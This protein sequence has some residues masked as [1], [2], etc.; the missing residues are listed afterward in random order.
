M[1]DS[2]W[3]QKEGPIAPE[4]G[5]DNYT[6]VVSKA[7]FAIDPQYM[8]GTYILLSL[9]G[10]SPD[11]SQEYADRDVRIP[12]GKITELKVDSADVD[13][14]TKIDGGNI[15]QFPSRGLYSEMIRRALGQWGIADVLKGSG[16]WF[17][18][19]SI[20]EGLRFRF[21]KETFEYKGKNPFTSERVFP[22]DYLGTGEKV[23]ISSNGDSKEGLHAQ[24]TA[25][26]DQA[27]SHEMF[28]A[29]AVALPAV[30]NDPE[31]LA[32]VTD[33]TE[34]EKRWGAQREEVTA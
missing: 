29:F 27:A 34:A 20:W 15:T 1:S 18:Q 30:K 28:V 6:M 22:T 8:Q 19:A 2:R 3:D 25:L 14:I 7:S 16:K 12:V 32:A 9:K 4:L 33:P 5:F 31:I 10:R 17:D 21:T 13:H 24:L 26:H 23:E 11:I